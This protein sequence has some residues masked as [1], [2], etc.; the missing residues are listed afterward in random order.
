MTANKTL[1]ERETIDFAQVERYIAA[2]RAE[3]SKAVHEAL[4]SFGRQIASLFD[5]HAAMQKKISFEPT[6]KIAP[7]H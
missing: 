4:R 1:I 2:G 7:K 3:R 5:L 6:V